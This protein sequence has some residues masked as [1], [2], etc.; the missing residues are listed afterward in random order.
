MTPVTTDRTER[1]ILD[2]LSIC[3]ITLREAPFA[4]QVRLIAQT[5]CAGMGLFHPLLPENLSQREISDVLDRNGLRSTICVPKPFTILPSAMFHSEDGRRVTRGTG[6]PESVEAM[7]DS[8]RWL[9][10]LQPASVI[11]IPGAQGDLSAAEAWDRSVDGLSK[12]A[13]AAADLGITLA[14]EPVH[15]RFARD[16][17]IL[18]TID[19]ALRMMDEVGADN[20]GVMIEV[21]HVW[22]TADLGGQ[23]QRAA[24]RIAG[25]QLS[26]SARYPRSQ[27]DRLPPGEGCADI[28][29]IVRAV[30]ATGYRGWYDIEIV[31]DN[32]VIGQGAYPDSAWNRPPEE[33][34]AACVKGSVDALRRAG[35]H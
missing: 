17:S 6:P 2:R 20:I 13:K 5:G 31:S 3:A 4:E 26:D 22:D 12:L 14:L 32:G 28:A 11:V 15:P 30:E 24:G 21:F 25:V 29:G 9:A 34:A 1:A 33:L 35:L 8:L 10:P 19:D 16:F 7:I 27:V 18:S 23:I